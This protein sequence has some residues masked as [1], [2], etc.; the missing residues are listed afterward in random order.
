MMIVP[1]AEQKGGLKGQGSTKGKS[2]L[3]VI[4]GL[5]LGNWAFVVTEEN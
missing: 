3:C 5:N 4:R 2:K 1:K